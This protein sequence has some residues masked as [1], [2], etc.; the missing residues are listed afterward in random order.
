ML[1]NAQIFGAA[2]AAKPAGGESRLLSLLPADALE[3][4]APHLERVSLARGTVLFEPGDRMDRVIFPEAGTVL[5][6]LVPGGGQKP[7]ESAMI[8]AE[9]AIGALLG[10]GSGLAPVRCAVLTGGTALQVPADRFG[11]LLG[12]VPALRTQMAQQVATLMAQLHQGTACA[13]LHAVEARVSRWLIGLQDRLGAGPLPMTQETLAGRL[14]VRRTTVT[15]VIATLESKGL[16]EHRRGRVH[17]RD[18]AGLEQ[19]SCACHAR[20]RAQFERLMPGIYP[21][22]GASRPPRRD[23]TGEG[24]MLEQAVNR[25]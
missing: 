13:A 17:V 16:I 20:I 5:S 9:G 10:T 4:L 1:D 19:A 23:A 3:R 21:A 22:A 11:A 25:A 7:I 24:S 15:R 2:L 6:L 12:A 14:G 18:R 8:G